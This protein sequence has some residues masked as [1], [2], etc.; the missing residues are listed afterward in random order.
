MKTI[1]SHLKT[2]ES[3]YLEKG[4]NLRK[5]TNTSSIRMQQRDQN[6]NHELLSCRRPEIVL[7]IYIFNF[8]GKRVDVVRSRKLNNYPVTRETI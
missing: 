2:I 1:E 3:D 7:T 6:R 4:N 8:T 5:R